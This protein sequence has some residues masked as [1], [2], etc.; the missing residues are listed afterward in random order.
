[1]RALFKLWM[2]PFFILF[3]TACA[4]GPKY[5]EV[6]SGFTPLDPEQGR[7]YIYRPSSFGAAVRPDVKLNGTVVGEAISYGFFYVDRAPGEYTIMTSTEVDR[8]LSLTLRAGQIRYVR[9]G[10][11]FGFAV[12]HVYPELVENAVGEEEIRKLHYTGGQ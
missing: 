9:L 8:S 12:G 10:I 3:L 4:S 5:S 2:L 1:M 7:I 6:A 11:S